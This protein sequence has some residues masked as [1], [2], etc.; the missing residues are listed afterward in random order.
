MSP[1]YGKQ[2]ISPRKFFLAVN[3]IQ[4]AHTGITNLLVG[5][6]VDISEVL[7]R[8]FTKKWGK[9]GV[10]LPPNEM[11]HRFLL[12]ARYLSLKVVKVIYIRIADVLI[13]S[14]SGRF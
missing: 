4:V 12:T 8:Y 6:N 10:K 7:S 11:N 1:N 2:R 9:M 5:R 14:F 13:L 3:T